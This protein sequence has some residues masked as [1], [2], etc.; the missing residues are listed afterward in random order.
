MDW[1]MDRRIGAS[2]AV[3][4]AE[5]EG[6]A[7]DLPVHLH[8]NLDLWSQALGSARKNEIADTSGQNEF[9]PQGGWAQP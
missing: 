7:L 2:S 9:P 1:E 3:M 6:E 5:P 8:S 4:Q